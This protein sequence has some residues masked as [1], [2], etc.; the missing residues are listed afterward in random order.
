MNLILARLAPRARRL[1]LLLPLLVAAGCGDQIQ[2]PSGTTVITMRDNV[3]NPQTVIVLR[4][5]TIRWSNN[6]AN[7]HTT[8]ADNGTWSSGNV[9]PGLTFSHTMSNAGT[10]GYRCTIHPGMTGTIIVD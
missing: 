9:T 7:I 3:F 1:V 6:G 8:V 2:G 10:F 4:N 5:A